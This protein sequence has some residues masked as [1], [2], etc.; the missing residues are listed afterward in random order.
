MMTLHAA[1]AAAALGLCCT[2]GMAANWSDAA[3]GLR[4]GTD[5]AE[6]AVGTGIKKTILSFTY[7]AGDNLGT[8][9]FTGDVL[10]SDGKDP[11]AGGG[12]GAQEFYGIFERSFSLG[13][14]SGR[15]EGYG[16]FKDLSLTVRADLSSKNTAFAPRVRKLRPGVSVALPV[17]AGFWNLGLQAYH[18]TN[19]NGIVGKDVRFKTTW[20]I[21]SA[22]SIPLGPGSLGGFLDVVG[23]KGKDGFGAD[24]KMETLLRLQYLFDVGGPKSGFKAGLAYEYWN[25]KFGNDS[26]KDVTGGARAKTPMLVAEYHF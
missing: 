19:H 24:T 17:P 22:W 14:M 1:A 9:F 8:S 15:K 25:N 2:A 26:A 12:S 5:F 20:A 21:A 18:E 13:A 11:D 7:V 6:P 23:P 3:V 16:P 10:K 4:Y